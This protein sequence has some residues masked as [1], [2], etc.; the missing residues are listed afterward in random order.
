[1]KSILIENNLSAEAFIKQKKRLDL[2]IIIQ[3]ILS[4]LCERELSIEE[5]VGKLSLSLAKPQSPKY[6]LRKYESNELKEIISLMTFL[7]DDFS[8]CHI[9]DE[10]E[11]Q[12]YPRFQMFEIIEIRKIIED[13]KSNPKRCFTDTIKTLFHQILQ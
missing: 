11:L 2:G 13:P 5:I 7:Y 1:L 12:L 9:I 8:D 3:S 10:P 4:Q 6:D